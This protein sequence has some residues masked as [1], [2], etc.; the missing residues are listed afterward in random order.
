M[1]MLEFV[2]IGSAELFETERE[3]KIQNENICLQWDLNPRPELR[4]R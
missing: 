2:C 1:I 3:R 4:D